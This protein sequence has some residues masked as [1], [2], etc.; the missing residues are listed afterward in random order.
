MFDWSRTGDETNAKSALASAS[1]GASE[2]FRN[3]AHPQPA[4]FF[5]AHAVVEQGGENSAIADAL[6]GTGLTSPTAL[7]C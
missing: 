3:I 6:G 4:P 7:S 1:R 2:Q 5:T